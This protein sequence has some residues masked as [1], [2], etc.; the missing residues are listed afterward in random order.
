M[1]GV[2]RTVE[3]LRLIAKHDGVRLT[4]VSRWLGIA[5]SSTY[6]LLNSLEQ[7]GMVTRVPRTK[8]Y[9]RGPALA[10]LVQPARD[11]LPEKARQ[12][13][14]RLVQ[15]SGETAHLVRLTGRG[16]EFIE[17]VESARLLRVAARTAM[18]M[19]AH[20]TAG[21]KA[22][23]ARR[24]D[25]EVVELYRDAALPTITGRTVSSVEDL[26]KHLRLARSRGYAVN[27]GETESDVVAVAVA[28]S[29]SLA[30]AVA[31][32]R[33]RLPEEDVP[34][35]VRLITQAASALRQDLD[36]DRSAP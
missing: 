18:T 4:E 33:Q 12:H 2:T 9:R 34:Y 7:L 11:A 28:M 6:R 22:L 31:A 23:L 15:R 21:G 29:D 24:S 3:A 30:L 25:A 19:P 20:A 14:E 32:P 5:P 27:D 13:I 26:L 36:V 17:T 10:E 35:L 1:L 16:T 8:L